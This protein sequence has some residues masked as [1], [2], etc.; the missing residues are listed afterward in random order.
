MSAKPALKELPVLATNPLRIAKVGTWVWAIA[1]A[2]AAVFQ[3][4]LVAAG[5]N[6]AVPIALAGVAL[7]LLGQLHVTRRN[8]RLEQNQ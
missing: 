7:G 4:Q 1:A 5:I 3:D 6:D 8:R 2:S